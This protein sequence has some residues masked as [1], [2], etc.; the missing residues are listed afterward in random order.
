MSV[1]NSKRGHVGRRRRVTMRF[2]LDR[3]GKSQIQALDRTQPLLPMRPGQAERRTHDDKRHGSFLALF[4]E[5]QIKRGSHRSA[6]V[7]QAAIDAFIDAR[8]SDP[9]PFRWTKHAD[10]IRPSIARFCR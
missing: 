8:N 10:D 3:D 2:V 5:L 7:Q 6:K 4:T 9:K 1:A